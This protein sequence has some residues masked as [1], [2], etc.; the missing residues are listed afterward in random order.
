METVLIRRAGGALLHLWDD[1]AGAGCDV[2]AG[3]CE[4]RV[5][6]WAAALVPDAEIVNAPA[7][8]AEE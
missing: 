6:A 3:P 7:D 8:P 1:A 2:P 4:A 5:P